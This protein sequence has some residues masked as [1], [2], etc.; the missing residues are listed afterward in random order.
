LSEGKLINGIL[1]KENDKVKLMTP[2]DINKFTRITSSTIKHRQVLLSYETAPLIMVQAIPFSG[3]FEELRFMLE[4]TFEGIQYAEDFQGQSG[5][6]LILGEA[7]HI[8]HVVDGR[9]SFVESLTDRSLVR[10]RR[11]LG[12]RMGRRK[13]GGH[14]GGRSSRRSFA[15]SISLY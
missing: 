7:V 2:D 11:L 5:N 14:F 6:R 15:G 4:V 12:R 1:A 3:S 9:L 10:E 13:S 8:I